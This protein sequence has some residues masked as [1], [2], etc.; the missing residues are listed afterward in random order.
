VLYGMSILKYLQRCQLQHVFMHK[1]Q[2]LP[3]VR[4]F[5]KVSGT[6]FLSLLGP[7]HIPTSTRPTWTSSSCCWAAAE[8]YHHRHHYRHHH[9][10][11]QQHNL[12]LTR[13]IPPPTGADE[14]GGA[15]SDRPGLRP[16]PEPDG[17]QDEV[18]PAASLPSLPSLTIAWMSGTM[19]TLRGMNH[20]ADDVT[21]AG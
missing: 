19:R 13:T 16:R 11:Q 21:G 10:Q 20:I 18:R 9:H 3:H 15:S 4:T 17:P 1:S 14:S 2:P 8:T 6:P 7:A 5:A 12:H